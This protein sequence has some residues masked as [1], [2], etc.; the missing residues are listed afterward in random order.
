MAAHGPISDKDIIGAIT[1]VMRQEAFNHKNLQAD[2]R[3]PRQRHVGHGD[4]G[5]HRLQHGLRLDA[6]E[7][8]ASR[9]RG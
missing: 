2:R 1:A 5:A 4:G 7:Q 6:A 9:I 8:P 3:P